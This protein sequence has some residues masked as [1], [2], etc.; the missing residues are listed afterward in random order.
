M[1][2]SP[3]VEHVCSGCELIEPL[4]ATRETQPTLDLARRWRFLPSPV[5]VG[6][7]LLHVHHL[8]WL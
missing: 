6:G 8:S 7:M 5:R 1:S 4:A 2:T 3:A